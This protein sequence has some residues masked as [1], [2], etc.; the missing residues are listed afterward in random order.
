M[1]IR[2]IGRWGAYPAAGEASASYLLEAGEQ[3]ILLDC[4]SGSLSALQRYVPLSSLTSAVI[5][6]QHHD[7]IADLGCLQYACLIDTDLK[8]RVEP[9]R[10]LLPREKA[11]DWP[12]KEMMGAYAESIS[13]TTV[14]NGENGLRL[15]FF[16]T[17]HDAYCLG[18]R[19]EAEGKVLVYTADTRYN[20]ALLPWLQ[21]A[22]LLI[23]ESSFYNGQDA[24]RYGHMTAAEA[25]RLAAKA[26]AKRLVLSHLPH[27][28]E[29]SL[30]REEAA[31]EFSGDIIL[32]EA[33]LQLTV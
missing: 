3:R 14:L 2:I 7:H 22:D 10:I 11:G 24:G 12:L 33:G 13:H 31:A 28:G 6:H 1:H 25:G 23:T 17:D 29:L 8:Q 16:R 32:P 21:D 5:S 9:L 19:I 4:G 15:S 20:E 26:G 30:L 18:T 27:F